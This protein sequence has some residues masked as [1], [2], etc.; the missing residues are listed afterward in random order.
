MQAKK[1]TLYTIIVLLVITLPL[2]IYGTVIHLKNK[3]SATDRENPN[4]E[5]HYKDKLYF[6][7]ENNELLSKYECNSGL[8][9]YPETIID[10]DEYGINYYSEGEEKEFIYNN[11]NYTFI[12]DNQNIMLF[13]KKLGSVL[14]NYSKIKN[15][16]T[17]LA[18]DLVIIK[19]GAKWGVLDLKSLKNILPYD[20]EFVGLPNKLI[21]GKLQTDHFIVLEKTWW[22]I[23]DKEGK[24]LNAGISH[25]IKDFNDQYII[26][27]ENKIYDYESTE[28]T[29]SMAFKEAYIVDNYIVLITNNNMILVYE[30]LNNP[31]LGH[32]TIGTYTKLSFALKDNQLE[33]YTDGTI[34]TTIDLNL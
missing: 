1:S 28:I 20:Y 3:P 30:D 27:S 32:G 17:A 11:G 13:D 31:M 8:C 29:P 10:D 12:V 19:Q 15:Y 4:H 23:F 22:Y 9:G 7:N 26:T 14:V 25:P 34:G 21:D 33:V 16:H 18:D 24:A 2:A 5:F 6:Y